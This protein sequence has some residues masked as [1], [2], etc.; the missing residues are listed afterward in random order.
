M[1]SGT[2]AEVK[3]SIVIALFTLAVLCVIVLFAT[4]VL[5]GF[6]IIAA[7]SEALSLTLALAALATALAAV[8]I[9]TNSP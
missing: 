4:G 6:G 9:T 5:S 3:R 8:M 7:K 2:E 1:P